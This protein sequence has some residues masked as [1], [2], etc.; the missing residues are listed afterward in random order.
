MAIQVF[1]KSLL[2]IRCCFA[3]VKIPMRTHDLLTKPAFAQLN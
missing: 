2:A 1:P 3:L